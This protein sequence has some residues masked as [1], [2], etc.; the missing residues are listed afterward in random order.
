MEMTDL[1]K[2]VARLV[3]AARG[4]S[5]LLLGE[6]AIDL[7]EDLLSVNFCDQINAVAEYLEKSS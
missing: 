3:N 6:D 1:Q 4:H 2:A 5:G 7:P